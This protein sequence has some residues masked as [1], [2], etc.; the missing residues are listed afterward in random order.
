MHEWLNGVHEPRIAQ[1]ISDYKDD[2]E[3]VDH[4]WIA[5]ASIMISEW[6]RMWCS[7]KA[8][9]MMTVVHISASQHGN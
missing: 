5:E 8:P 4:A 6:E 3:K 7:G 9:K 2:V 1:V